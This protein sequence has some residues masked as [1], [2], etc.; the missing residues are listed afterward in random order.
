MHKPTVGRNEGKW[1]STV[2][3]GPTEN[4]ATRKCLAKQDA[5]KSGL[6]GD[7][8]DSNNW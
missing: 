8:D 3:A 4:K 2:F 7:Q 6:Y 5:G 1:Q